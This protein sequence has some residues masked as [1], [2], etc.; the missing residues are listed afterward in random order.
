[1]A[2]AGTLAGESRRGSLDLVPRR[3]SAGVALRSR[4]P[5]G[6][7]DAGR[8]DAVI[9]I[10]TAIAGSAFAALP[11]DEIP[12]GAAFSFAPWLGLMAVAAG[13]LAFALAPFV[14]RGSAAGLVGRGHAGGFLLNGYRGDPAAGAVREPHLV[15]LDRGPHSRWRAR[16]TPSP[17]PSSR[18]FSLALLAIGVEAFARRDLGAST[19][20]P[21]PRLPRAM[22]GLRGPI[23]RA[24]SERFPTGLSWGV[25]LGLFGL[26]IAGSGASFIEQIGE[27]PEFERVLGSLFPGIDIGTVGGFLQL[28]FIE[29]GLVMAGLAAAG[30]VGGW[31][32]D[33]RSGRLEML[34]SAPV[35]R[36]WWPLSGGVGV[37]AAIVALVIVT[38]TGIAIG[39]EPRAVTS[40]RRCSGRRR[41]ASTRRP[42]P[43]SESRSAGSSPAFAA[44]TVV[45]PDAHHLAGRSRR[46]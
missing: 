39:A 15:G 14:G 6:I 24:T 33:E 23:G 46:R 8:G 29:F 44:P 13:S 18:S 30:L 1:M 32:S 9:G 36:R 20:I 17:S 7:S 31:A 12:P 25:G 42:W 38:A 3:R 35:A 16:S 19:A 5:A 21:G 27:S 26:I 41:S 11:G 4:R 45:A 34:L 40:G 2:L 10:S 22:L 37:L 28:V 43:A